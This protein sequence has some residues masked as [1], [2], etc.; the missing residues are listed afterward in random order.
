MEDTMQTITFGIIAY[1]EQQ[2]LPDLLE[3]LLN[4]TYLKEKIE[5]IMVDGNSS[6]NTWKIMEKFKDDHEKE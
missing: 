5:V 3:D 4:Q 2:Y 6:D 1:N